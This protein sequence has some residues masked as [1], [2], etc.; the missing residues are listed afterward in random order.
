MITFNVTYDIVTPES[1]EGGDA[2]ER[3]FIL[4]NARLRHAVEAACRPT[5]NCRSD[6]GRAARWRSRPSSEDSRASRRRP[7]WNGANRHDPG[8]HND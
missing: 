4:E 8:P 7:Q 2:A 1:A 5:R 6:R 3:G